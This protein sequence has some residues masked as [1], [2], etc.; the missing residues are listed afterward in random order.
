MESLLINRD[1]PL[2]NKSKQSVPLELFDSWGI[3][4]LHMTSYK[5]DSSGCSSFILKDVA[6]SNE[7]FLLFLGCPR[8]T[9]GHCQRDSLTSPILITAFF[10]FLIWL[11]GHQEPHNEVG[12]QSLVEQ[13]VEL[14]PGSFWFSVQCLNP[15][16]HSSHE[17]YI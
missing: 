7:F 2:L 5:I 12:S 17:F 1:H 3:K 9:L 4:F 14:E 8:P 13:P 15:L 10:K 16:G 6:L 11:E